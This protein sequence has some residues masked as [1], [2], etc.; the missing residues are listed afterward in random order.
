MQKTVT[1][2]IEI[3]TKMQEQEARRVA[4]KIEQ[5]EKGKLDRL[6]LENNA[7]VEEARK[8]FLQLKSESD[9]VKSKGQAMAEARAKAE[10]AEIA[11]NADVTFAQ[12]QANAKRVR[13][14]A[15]IEHD[16]QKN[17]IEL[18][19]QKAMSTLKIKQTQELAQIES[20]KFKTIM[21]AIGKETLVDIAM[22]GPEMQGKMLSSLGLQG[23]MLMDSQNPINLF[24]TAAGLIGEG[25]DKK[26]E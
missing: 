6:I 24:T 23:Y 21:D 8:T 15:E 1:Q 13:E 9:A 3:T 4:N 18:A 26:P 5:E 12:L 20:A 11:A 16:K 2:A 19:H 7:K 17:A 25:A 10:A 22:A 14:I